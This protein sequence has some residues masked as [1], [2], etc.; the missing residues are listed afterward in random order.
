MENV[1]SCVP[2]VKKGQSEKER[3]RERERARENQCWLFVCCLMR[4]TKRARTATT[5]IQSVV[6]ARASLNAH[7]LYAFNNVML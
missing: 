1:F 6:C 3:Y 5:L 2:N 7:N 4:R